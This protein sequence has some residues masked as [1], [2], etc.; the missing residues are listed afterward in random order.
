MATWEE[1]SRDCLRSAKRLLEE[2]LFR[3][4]I[5]SSYYAAYCA[6][7]AELVAKGVNFAHGWRNP[8]HEQLV[9]LVMNNINLPRN[10][11]YELRKAL[12]LTRRAREDADY[13]PHAIIDER[14]AREMLQLAGRVIKLLEERHGGTK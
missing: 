2:E 8:A 4:S 10:A 14:I 13:R 1:M 11:K 3:R 12:K 6:V 9:E 7:T 5:S